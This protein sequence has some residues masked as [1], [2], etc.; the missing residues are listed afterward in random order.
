M[1]RS[2]QLCSNMLLDQCMYGTV[3]H[4]LIRLKAVLH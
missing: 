3:L 1:K 4:D 2:I